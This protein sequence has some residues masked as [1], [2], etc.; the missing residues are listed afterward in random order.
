MDL[1]RLRLAFD[2]ES[3]HTFSVRDVGVD[4]QQAQHLYRDV[5]YRIEMGDRI[6]LTIDG[7]SPRK[8]DWRTKFT[9]DE[10]VRMY[11]YVSTEEWMDGWGP[12]ADII[13]ARS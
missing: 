1:T 4:K 8:I 10:V 3:K 2:R 6:Q 11:E 13:E 7:K 9:G 12:I 5:E